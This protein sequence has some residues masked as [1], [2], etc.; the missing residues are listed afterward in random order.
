MTT[1]APPRDEVPP[2]LVDEALARFGLTR[3]ARFHRRSQSYI[4]IV[5]DDA[6]I[7]R[8]VPDAYQTRAEIDSEL[9]WH[10]HLRQR[11]VSV[12]EPLPTTD[13][14]WVA[15][16]PGYSVAAYRFAPG[17]QLRPHEAAQ[18][19]RRDVHRAWGRLLARLHQ[20]TLTYVPTPG[21]A[22]RE[23][24]RTERVFQFAGGL[25]HLPPE[26]HDEW[27]RQWDWMSALPTDGGTFGLTHND[28]HRG[29][30]LCDPAQTPPLITLFDMGGAFDCWFAYDLAQPL[31]Y[32]GPVFFGERG[33]TPAQL[34]ELRDDLVAGYRD[35]RPLDDAWVARIRSFVRV[36]QLQMCCAIR[37]QIGGP[38]EAEW[39]E[40]NRAAIDRA[41]ADD[42]PPLC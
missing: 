33:A 13:G 41:I 5:G 40:R 14:T 15:S 27:R 18:D 32:S 29:N 23:S 12:S 10:S 11:G 28:A 19:W 2:A 37:A 24:W 16:V 3:P 4:Y 7:L 34:D 8:L 42:E 20:A 39:F 38:L 9:D 36:R 6:Q 22:P 31:Y 21:I 35:V 30:W 26:L 25:E 1:P 17:R